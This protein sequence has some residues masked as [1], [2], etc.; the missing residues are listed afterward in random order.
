[1]NHK[2]IKYEQHFGTKKKIENWLLSKYR[3]TT[4][5]LNKLTLKFSADSFYKFNSSMKSIMKNSIVD[6]ILNFAGIWFWTRW[7]LPSFCAEPRNWINWR[8]Q[9]QLWSMASQRGVQYWNPMG[10]TFRW[11]LSTKKPNGDMMIQ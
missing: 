5:I 7:Q 9:S 10:T 8:I 11:I 6:F 1:M 2:I 4:L 3:I